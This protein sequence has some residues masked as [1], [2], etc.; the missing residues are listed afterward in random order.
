L[1][2]IFPPSKQQQELND[3]IEILVSINAVV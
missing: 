1:T 2:E 3:E